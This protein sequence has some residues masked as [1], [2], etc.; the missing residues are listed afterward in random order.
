MQGEYDEQLEWPFQGKFTILLLSQE[1]ED[2]FTNTITAHASETTT[3]I[4][5]DSTYILLVDMR[6]KYLK[7]DCIKIRISKIDVVRNRHNIHCLLIT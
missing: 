4:W 5:E 2:H 1:D 7:N 6:P 3:R